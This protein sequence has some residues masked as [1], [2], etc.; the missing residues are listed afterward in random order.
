MLLPGK[1]PLH[2]AVEND[3]YEVA[4]LLLNHGALPNTVDESG[5]LSLIRQ[6][7]VNTLLY[8]SCYYYAG[9]KKQHTPS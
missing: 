7:I 8:M 5:K 2:T 3:H 9:I 6:Y 4:E 1:T